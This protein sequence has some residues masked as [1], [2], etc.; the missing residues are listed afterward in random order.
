M[1]AGHPGNAQE[2]DNNGHVGEDE[3]GGTG[4]ESFT[5]YPDN[6]YVGH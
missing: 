5:I 1:T 6:L 2:S 3:L 4:E